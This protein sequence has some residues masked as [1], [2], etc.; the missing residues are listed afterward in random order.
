MEIIKLKEKINQMQMMN[1]SDSVVVWD[2]WD[3]LGK[4]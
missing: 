3:R 1:N 4:N 2:R